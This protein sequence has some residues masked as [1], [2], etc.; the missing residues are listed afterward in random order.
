MISFG[1]GIAVVSSAFAFLSTA[2]LDR[3]SNTAALRVC[4]DIVC[5]SPTRSTRCPLTCRSFA[6]EDNQLGF[7]RE[8]KIR[9]LFIREGTAQHSTED[10]TFDSFRIIGTPYFTDLLDPPLSLLASVCFE[11]TSWFILCTNFFSHISLNEVPKFLITQPGADRTRNPIQ[12]QWP[13]R[14]LSAKNMSTASK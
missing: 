6:G 10:S 7:A 13:K 3:S 11:V 1:S 5:Q 12:G 2:G 4:A 14:W 8:S 9:L